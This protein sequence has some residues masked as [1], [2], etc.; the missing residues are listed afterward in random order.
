MSKEKFGQKESYDIIVSD[1][2][3]IIKY[4]DELKKG[5]KIDEKNAPEIVKLYINPED[6]SVSAK[7]EEQIKLAK[8]VGGAGAMAAVAALGTGATMLGGGAAASLIGGAAAT[9]LGATVLGGGAAASLIGGTA[10]TGLSLAGA[11]ASLLTPIGIP[12]VAV[13][14]SL[15][16]GK[17]IHTFKNKDKSEKLNKELDKAIAYL[18]NECKEKEKKYQAKFNKY[19]KKVEALIEKYKPIVKDKIKKAAILADDAINVDVN[20]RIMQYQQIALNQYADIK[21]LN[22]NFD[23]IQKKYNETVKELREILE[24]YQKLEKEKNE[25]LAELEK[26]RGLISAAAAKSAYLTSDKQKKVKE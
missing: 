20:K 17:T 9:G 26:Y 13:G 25:L 24:E 22:D 7:K 19:E 1:S 8:S 4:V 3:A 18:V 21:N 15:A 5:K 10:A 23:D 6:K 12:L 16:I 2:E 11:S 14:L